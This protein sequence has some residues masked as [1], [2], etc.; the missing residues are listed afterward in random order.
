MLRRFVAAAFAFAVSAL[1]AATFA[2]YVNQPFYFQAYKVYHQQILNSTGTGSTTGTAGSVVYATGALN[3]TSVLSIWCT[4]NDTV[5][6]SLLVS[7]VS[8]TTLYPIAVVNIPAGAGTVA[9][10][11]GVQIVSS[12]G[13]TPNYIG[14][15]N[16]WGDMGL[17]VAATDT[18]DIAVLTTAVTTGDNI[19]CTGSGGDF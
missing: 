18:I 12:A 11:P 13:A 9:G 15:V 8:G 19:S 14:P 17:P 4:S 7:Y 2:A 3:G 16:A 1:P 6:H 5:A 10:T